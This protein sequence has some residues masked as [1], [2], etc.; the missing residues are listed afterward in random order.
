MGY[1]A[2]APEWLAA[3]PRLIRAANEVAQYGGRVEP[4]D[5]MRRIQEGL[6]ERIGDPAFL[7]RARTL[8]A[9]ATAFGVVALF[10]AG[11]RLGAS[12]W[13]GVV[14]AAV[15]ALSWEVDTHARHIAIDG[16]LVA[17]V[18]AFLAL[19]ARYLRPAPDA[20]P[21]ERW[22]YG[23]AAVAGIATGAKFHALLLLVPLV[24]VVL[25]RAERRRVPGL[26][27]AALAAALVMNPGLLFD[28]VQVANDWGYTAID[29]W[30]D[31]RPVSDPYKS[32]GS[33]HHLRE[34]SAWMV[35]AALSPRPWLG[36][37]L[38]GVAA[39]GAVASFRRDWKVTLALGA[40]LPIY[41]LVMSRSGLVIVRNYLPVLPVLALFVMWG[42]EAL[43]QPGSRRR[44]LAVALCLV[45]VPV[46]C[47]HMLWTARTVTRPYDAET[48][49][50]EIRDHIRAHPDRHFLVSRGLQK[51]ADSL[52]ASFSDLGN[53]V[54]VFRPTA[55]F[56]AFVYQPSEYKGQLPG[57]PRLGYF[58]EVFG[59]REVNYDYYPNWIGHGLDRRAYVIDDDLARPLME[60]LAR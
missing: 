25:A 6:R 41:L 2:L 10:L 53:V 51:Q 50:R 59:S 19:L 21:S 40:F 12:P 55:R 43:W 4:T 20:R 42:F 46:N 28:T 1:L 9:A 27:A 7:I 52:G 54:E 17:L 57:A 26:L 14:A 49:V 44:W 24:G 56:D 35:G 39:L 36:L 23:A 5:E 3:L 15:V 22:L 18:A 37:A 38:F 11:A 60:A 45:W 32:L 31:T 58:R 34:A 13:S 16:I 8:F 33:L 30:R 29:Y 47:W 48:L